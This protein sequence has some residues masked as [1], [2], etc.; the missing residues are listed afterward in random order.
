[1]QK[2]NKFA[3]NKKG[4]TLIEVFVV[5]AMM[6]ALTTLGGSGFVALSHARASKVANSLDVLLSQSKVNALSGRDNTLTVFYN[7]T[8]D[9]DK[10]YKAKTYYGTLTDTDGVYEV[11]E[12]GNRLVTINFKNTKGT[13]NVSAKDNIRISFDQKT[14]AVSE[15]RMIDTSDNAVLVDTDNKTEFYIQSGSTYMVELFKITG[16]HRVQG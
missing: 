8:E 11:A 7:E 1:M 16:E 2:L 15:C 3:D 6:V 10:G 4:F 12:L 13:K 9:K 5:V 14:G